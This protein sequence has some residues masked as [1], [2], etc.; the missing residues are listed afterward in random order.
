MDLETNTTPSSCVNVEVLESDRNPVSGCVWCVCQFNERLM[1]EQRE[2]KLQ[3]L[4]LG[5]VR[6]GG[7]S[8][9]S[10]HLHSH[11]HSEKSLRRS[12]GV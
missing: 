3:I 8:K 11:S 7:H 9:A 2:V 4:E 12:Y 1:E 5:A 10:M 6:L